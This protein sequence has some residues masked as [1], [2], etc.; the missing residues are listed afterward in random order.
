M[1]KEIITDESVKTLSAIPKTKKKRKLRSAWF[2]DCFKLPLKAP[3]KKIK[4]IFEIASTN[5]LYIPKIRAIVPPETPGI[6]SANPITIPLKK[7]AR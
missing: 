6:N 1:K 2:Q 7:I 5:L 4:F 3:F